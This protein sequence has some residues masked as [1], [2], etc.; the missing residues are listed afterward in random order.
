MNRRNFLTP[1]LSLLFVLPIFSVKA[2]EPAEGVPTKSLNVLTVGNSFSICLERY[3]PSVV[4]SVPGCDVTLESI[5]IGGCPLERHWGN[6]V[7]EEADPEKRH[8]KEFTYRQKFE[9]KKWDVISIQQSSP[10]SW[11]PESYFPYAEQLCDYIRKYAPTAE[12]VIQ[13][14]WSYRAD[15]G[16]LAQWGIDQTKMYE[17][18]FAAYNEAAAKLNLRVIPVGLAIQEARKN[19]PGGYEQLDRSKFVYPDLPDMNRYFLG[20]LRWDDSKKLVGDAF[21]LNRR[22]DYLQACVWFAVL[23]GRSAEEVTFVP[24]EITADDAVF[25]RRMAQ[26]AVEEFQQVKK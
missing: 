9:S 3:F 26:K 1:F 19:Q 5:Y 2:E 10:L 6:I 23:Y 17:A 4:R 11:K 25:L 22:G 13:Q 12:I 21:H 7:R 24:K 16:R 20:N 14:T 8:F 18:L 15:D